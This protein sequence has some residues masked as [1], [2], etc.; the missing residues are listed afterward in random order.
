MKAENPSV[1]LARVLVDELVRCGM[2]DAVIAPGSRSAA[3]AM[4]LDA[5]PRVH[6]HVRIDERSASFLA[7]G[8]AKAS[9]RPAAV[10][11]T[12]GTAAANLHPAVLEAHEARVPLLVL[13]ADRPPELRGTGA[14]QTTDQIKLYG[15]AVRW[16]CE[17]GVPEDVPG[18]PAYWRATACR[19]WAEATGSPA[20]PV[21]LNLA[22]RE[23]LTPEAD[24]TFGEALD[25]RA[26]GAP[27]VAL[28]PGTVRPDD[29][30]LDEL[31][32]E[33]ASAERG[34]LFAGDGPDAA[35]LVAVA[36]RLGWPVLAEPTSGARHGAHAIGTAALLAQAEAFAAAHQPDLVLR[37]G[38]PQLSRPVAA[39]AG[40]GVERQI[41]IDP[42]GAWLDP[43]RALS[44]IVRGDITATAAGLLERLAPREP[45]EW[46]AGWRAAD[47]RARAAVDALL[48]A[49]GLTEP[50]VARDV[51][52]AVPPGGTLVV[53]S[54]MPIRDLDQVMAPR[55]DIR[56]LANR[57]VSGI[58]GFV[59]TAVG[60]ALASGG[61]TVALCGDL[62]LLH[63]ANGLLGA[64]AD[65]TIVVVNN[66]GGGIFSFL[67]QARHP[68]GFER[69]F[70]TPHGADLSSLAAA[71]GAA[72]ELV[73][74]P[75]RLHGKE[76]VNGG[77]R[78][79][80]VRTDRAANVAL[81]RRLRDAVEA[82]LA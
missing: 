68:D 32:A 45:G 30:V 66:D 20:G 6:L 26:G 41:L 17:V 16:F 18:M 19:A 5:E 70:G 62:S 53:G 33:L 14:N 64:D 82:A 63:D 15:D 44:R 69:V 12:S 73:H 38:R 59:S 3:L 75:E 47:A 55:G 34:L 9:G 21:H 2:T 39:L 81:H 77:V 51:A 49:E 54:S 56:V 50:R 76:T 23:P 52:A 1:A 74:A 8:L 11:C 57:G 42:D 36:E 27:W 58:D 4:A 37:V 65:L 72:H 79:L 28:A 22:M 31:A 67:P 13:T 60:I 80:E 24:R 10:L 61:P 35:P 71:Y 43:G 7:L 78:I 46:L 25:G 40:R 48:D 29:A